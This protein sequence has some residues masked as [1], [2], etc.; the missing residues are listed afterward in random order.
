MTFFSF[1]MLNA[2]AAAQQ[3]SNKKNLKQI[4]TSFHLL[5]LLKFERKMDFAMI[6]EGVDPACPPYPGQ[7][8]SLSCMELVCRKL[9]SYG[10]D[11]QNEISRVA[12]L[13]ATQFDGNCIQ[14]VCTKLGSYGC[15]DFQ[16]IQ[17]ATAICDGNFGSY[18]LD[19][20]C[21]KLGS[22]GCD[23]VSELQRVGLSCSRANYNAVECLKYSCTQL[24]S[25][26]CDDF[27]EVER[28]L[29]S[30]NGHP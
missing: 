6:D 21:S 24:G 12:Q 7:G 13:C 3:G 5:K 29:K 14:S 20:V 8:T 22:Y 19:T 2:F 28:V 16:E 15:D 18:C 26:S 23:D 10:C 17:R 11:D 9:G 1:F 27:S 4:T 30:C 25:Y